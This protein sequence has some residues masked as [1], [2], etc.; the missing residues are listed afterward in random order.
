MEKYHELSLLSW[1]S[2]SG[3][4]WS[5]VP[6]WPAG[7]AAWATTAFLPWS[8]WSQPRPD[9]C[10]SP[11]DTR[12]PLSGFLFPRPRTA[13]PFLW[14]RPLRLLHLDPITGYPSFTLAP[15][16][17]PQAP[18]PCTCVPLNIPKPLLLPTCLGKL[19]PPLG[20]VNLTPISSPSRPPSEAAFR[21]HPI[22]GAFPGRWRSV[23]VTL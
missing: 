22:P 17:A 23:P 7:L 5:G 8:S 13:A 3:A 10:P 18:G 12:L 6:R 2:A 11:A 21:N 19:A 20:T 4:R 9:P 1:A 15:D 16:P 14:L